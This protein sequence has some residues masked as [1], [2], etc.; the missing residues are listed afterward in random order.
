[1][2]QAKG[3]LSRACIDIRSPLFDEGVHSNAIERAW[4]LVDDAGLL[5]IP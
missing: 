1:M 2:P 3:E 4:D 5:R